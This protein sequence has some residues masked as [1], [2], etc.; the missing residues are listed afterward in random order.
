M[1]R[2]NRLRQVCPYFC[3][4]K[5]WGPRLG[6][7]LP[8]GGQPNLCRFCRRLRLSEPATGI[9]CV[10]RNDLAPHND[11]RSLGAGHFHDRALPVK[12][13]SVVPAEKFYFARA[14]A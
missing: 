8:L 1:R 12:M 11:N 10:A 9:A 5:T 14:K 2:Q 13:L 3:Y 4:R 7:C 6:L